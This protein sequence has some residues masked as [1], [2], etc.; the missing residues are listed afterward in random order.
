M[1]C[2][3]RHLR[4]SRHSS[5]LAKFQGGKKKSR[6]VI[7]VARVIHATHHL[8]LNSKGVGK[9]NHDLSL[10]S[11]A[12]FTPLVVRHS[13]SRVQEK[14]SMICHLRRSRHS[15]HSSFALNFE[16]AGKEIHDLSLTSLKSFTP[17]VV[18]H[19][20]SRVRDNKIM[21]CHSRR[22]CHSRHSSF[23]TQFKGCGKSK[24]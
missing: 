9:E 14:K 10:M 11:L 5:F 18:R 15:R 23:V 19:S 1:I 2:Q 8:S 7:P 22:L 24:S 17:L 3:S 13:I 21:V 20:I 12:S 16:G 6:F 4:H